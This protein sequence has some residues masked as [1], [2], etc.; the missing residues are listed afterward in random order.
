VGTQPRFFYRRGNPKNKS[1]PGKQEKVIGY[2]QLFS[3]L[4]RAGHDPQR[5]PH[6]TQRQLELYYCEAVKQTCRERA[7]FI[8]DIFAGTNGG[9]NATQL[10]NAL[11]Q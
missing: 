4:V 2:G 1:V 6:Y 8:V 11:R 10:I 3:T 9:N 5:L 7:D